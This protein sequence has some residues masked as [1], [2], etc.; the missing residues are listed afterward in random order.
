MGRRIVIAALA[1]TGAGALALALYAIAVDIA[2]RMT[3][4][5]MPPIDEMSEPWGDC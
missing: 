4:G 1:L 5:G 3:G 2:L